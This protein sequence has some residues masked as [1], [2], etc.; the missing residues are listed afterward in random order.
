M[1]S[2]RFILAFPNDAPNN[3]FKQDMIV[4]KAQKVEIGE[5]KKRKKEEETRQDAKQ[6][7]KVQSLNEEKRCACDGFNLSYHVANSLKTKD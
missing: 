5:S 4:N 6:G 7:V 3:G 2:N 1:I